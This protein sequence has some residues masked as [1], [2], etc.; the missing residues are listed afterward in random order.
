MAEPT[1]PRNDARDVSSESS[2][3]EA[4]PRWPTL[5]RHESEDHGIF[6]IHQVDRRSPRTDRVGTYKVLEV[7]AW[8]NVVAV[9][10]TD[11]GPQIVL[12][13]QF[14]HGIDD[15][16][17]EIPG[18]MIDPG[19]D[20]ADAAARELLEE[21]GYAGDASVEI[22]MVHPNPAIQDNVCYTYLVPNVR[23]VAEPQPDEGEHL[24]VV[25]EPLDALPELVRSGRITHSLVVAAFHWL[26]LHER[27]ADGGAG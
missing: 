27:S 6:R 3:G 9:H 14:R 10:E 26:H 13:E 20:P 5:R 23:L 8:V 21:T 24:R 2:D 16:T 12:V 4:L 17:L 25:L 11:E 19:E 22:G 15:L 18:G 7:P 1:E